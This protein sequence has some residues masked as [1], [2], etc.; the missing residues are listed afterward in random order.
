MKERT[1]NGGNTDREVSVSVTSNIIIIMLLS[2]Y[3]RG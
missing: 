1:R 2:H 3:L